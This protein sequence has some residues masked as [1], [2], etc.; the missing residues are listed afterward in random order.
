MGRHGDGTWGGKGMG[1]R[2]VRGRNGG[3]KVRQRG[4][5]MCAVRGCDVGRRGDA[6]WGGEEMRR[7]AV[8]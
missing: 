6:M 8:K 2:A 4:D 7:G 3:G 1:R 5:A